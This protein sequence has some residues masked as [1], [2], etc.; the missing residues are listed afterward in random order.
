MVRAPS[1]TAVDVKLLL[2]ARQS[3]GNSHKGLV[4]TNG[5]LAL[6]TDYHSS[7]C[8]SCSSCSYHRPHWELSKGI[9]VEI[10][11]RLGHLGGLETAV[12]TDGQDRIGFCNRSSLARYRLGLKATF[13]EL[14]LHVI[15]AR[16]SRG[17]LQHQVTF[18]IA[19][20]SLS[21][22]SLQIQL[23]NSS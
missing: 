12:G 11:D 16:A 7:S 18:T 19:S 17:G 10:Q 2:P 8:S 23:Q 1:I 14:D 9:R 20:S 5:G 21:S 4:W 6:A 13:D 3:R 15:L 22:D